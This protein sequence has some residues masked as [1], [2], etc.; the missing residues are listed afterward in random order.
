MNKDNTAGRAWTVEASASDIGNFGLEIRLL[1]SVIW[2]NKSWWNARAECFARHSS[3]NYE[4][5]LC[6]VIVFNRFFSLFETVDI[7]LVSESDS[8]TMIVVTNQNAAAIHTSYAESFGFQIFFL[9]GLCCEKVE[10]LGRAP[11]KD[12]N[13][14]NLLHCLPSLYS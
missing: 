2:R 1:R 12:S 3:N 9:W 4:S 11:L 14:I 6:Y 7:F 8:H 13:T 5:D 10:G